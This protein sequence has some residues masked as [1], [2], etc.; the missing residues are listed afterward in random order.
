MLNTWRGIHTLS[1]SHCCI[2]SMLLSVPRWYSSDSLG[3]KLLAYVKPECVVSVA[4]AQAV[5]S[6]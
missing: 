3:E 6:T 1:S 4:I 5:A 2:S